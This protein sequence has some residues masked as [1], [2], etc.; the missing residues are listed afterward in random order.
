MF[1]A[2]FLLV[3]LW[4]AAR[5]ARSETTSVALRWFGNLILMLLTWM[6]AVLLPFLTGFGTALIAREHGWGLFNT[7]PLPEAIAIPLGFVALD[8]LGYWQH[9]LF[10]A[11]PFMWR[12]HALHHSDPDLDVTTTVRHHP[13]EVLFQLLLD[14]SVGVVFGFPPAAIALYGGTVI[15]VQTF[16]H[17]NIEL[18]KALRWIG[19]LII[20]PELHRVHHSIAF[21]ENNS[22]FS[23]LFPLWD[24]LFGT[25]RP[26]ARENLRLGLPELGSAKFQRLDKMIAA[27]WFTAPVP[28]NAA[29]NFPG[30]G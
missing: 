13:L 26:Q 23:N 24:R 17:G 7:V 5:P 4:E 25:F 6:I 10:H 15:A 19:A 14:A 1:P 9:R 30:D 21:D 28:Q 16:H 29:S 12:L 27:P 22:N 18:P 3:A 20:T 11:V 2:A 8:L